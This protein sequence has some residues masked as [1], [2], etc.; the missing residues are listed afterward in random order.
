MATFIALEVINSIGGDF[1]NGEQLINKDNIVAVQQTA[2]GTCKILTN[3]PTA[4]QNEIEVQVGTNQSGA[5]VSP[6][7]ASGLI[8]KAINYALTGNP[9]GVKARVFLG[10]DD[11]G[12][13]MYV[14]N[15]LFS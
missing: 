2:D 6:V 11:N 5:I 10:K 4:T 1:D 15:V 12:D 3:T 14:R 13:Q 9:G 8:T 7:M